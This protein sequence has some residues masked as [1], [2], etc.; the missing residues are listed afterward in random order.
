MPLLEAVVATNDRLEAVISQEADDA[1]ESVP[2][3]VSGG[4]G[5][6][7]GAGRS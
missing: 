2:G 7:S 5:W 1:R 4:S 6:V 3:G